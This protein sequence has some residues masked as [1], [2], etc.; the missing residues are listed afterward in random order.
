M[1]TTDSKELR[2]LS[3]LTGILKIMYSFRIKQY[4]VDE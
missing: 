1:G 4:I 2:N 3:I